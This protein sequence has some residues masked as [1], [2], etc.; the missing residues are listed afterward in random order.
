MQIEF[1]CQERERQRYQGKRV[2]ASGE[3]ALVAYPDR[4]PYNC[5]ARGE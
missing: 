3:F 5:G 2:N 1:I 4:S